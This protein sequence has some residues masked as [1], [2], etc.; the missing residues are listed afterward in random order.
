MQNITMKE[1]STLVYIRATLS[2]NSNVVTKKGNYCK[3][4]LLLQV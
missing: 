2:N 4:E 3:I 1:N